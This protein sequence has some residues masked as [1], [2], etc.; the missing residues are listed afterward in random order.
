MIMLTMKSVRQQM[1]W[2][3]T[4]SWNIFTTQKFIGI[5]KSF[6]RTHLDYDDV[7]YN[8]CNASSSCKIVS[9]QCNAALPITEA[10]KSSSG[11]RLYQ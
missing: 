3:F 6:I 5:Y 8:S 10:I 7:T 4:V 9:V 1:V 11:D 2:G